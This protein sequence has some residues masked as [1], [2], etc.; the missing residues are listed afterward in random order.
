MMVLCK[1][2]KSSALS[3]KKA[4]YFQDLAHSVIP[5]TGETAMTLLNTLNSANFLL[6]LHISKKY[7][8]LIS[9]LLFKDTVAHTILIYSNVMGIRYTSLIFGFI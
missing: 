1:Y 9:D 2:R 8:D 5:N 4:I 3:F 7:M 6:L